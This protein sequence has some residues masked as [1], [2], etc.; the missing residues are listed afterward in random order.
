MKLPAFFELDGKFAAMLDSPTGGVSIFKEP[1]S[2]NV[3]DFMA[4]GSV[5]TMEELPAGLKADVV[6]R[7]S[8]IDNAVS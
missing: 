6:E 8:A 7:L 4:D 3:A 2:R 1:G 5:V